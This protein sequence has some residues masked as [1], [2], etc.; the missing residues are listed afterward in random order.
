MNDQVMSIA[1]R[2]QELSYYLD[3][4]PYVTELDEIP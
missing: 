2:E 4:Q 1:K 3:R